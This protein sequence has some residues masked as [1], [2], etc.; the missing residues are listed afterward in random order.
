[1]D[2]TLAQMRAALARRGNPIEMQNI[3]V[4]EAPDISPKAYMPPDNSRSFQPAPGGVAT[5]SGMPVGG[6]DQ[7][8]M[9][10]GQQLMPFSAVQQQQNL[11]G[12][13]P[14][15]MPTGLPGAQG[16]AAPQPPSNILSMTPQGRALSAM[17]PPAVPQ[18]AKGGQPPSDDVKNTRMV[19]NAEG[20]GGVKGI[21]VPRHM[22]EGSKTM[23]GM[24]EVNAARAQ[25]YGEEQRPPLTIGQIGKM[26]RNTLQQHFA[27]PLEQ[28]IEDERAA[29]N[30][31]REAKHI[32]K[33]ADTL[34]ESEK[35][36]T[37]RHERD[38]Q[39][40]TYVGYAS[41][42]VAGH[43]LYTSGHGED[44]KHHVLNTCPGQTEGCGGGKDEKGIVDTTKGTCFAPVA[45][46]Q[47]P[48]AAIRRASHAQA[49]HDPAMTND[50]ILAHTGSIRNAANRAD[51]NNQVL[52]FRPN[53]VD[54][55]DTSSRYVIKHLNN[56]RK[57][58]GKP[59]I[60]ANSYGKT[61]ELHD[62]ENG[63][64]VTHSNVGPK[65][66]HG[67]SIA[68]NI[69]RDNQ[70]VRSTIT[71]TT[72]GGKD[73]EN[74]D[75]NKTPPKGSYMVTNV[76]RGSQRSQEMEKHIKYAKYWSTGR[77]VDQLSKDE[78]DEG[79]EG[80]YGPK[81]K[82][83]TPDKAH[84]GHVTVN[85]KRYDYQK[86]HILHPRLVQVGHNDDGSPHMIPTDSR[87]KDEEFLPKN[88]FMTKNGKMAGHILMTTPTTS[89][90]GVQHHSSFTHD[91]SQEDIEH[92]KKNNGEY[93]IDDPKKQ[94]A[95]AGKEYVPPQQI[96][97]IKKAAGGSIHHPHHEMFDDYMAY[98]ERS[99]MAQMHL[100]RRHDPEEKDEW[101]YPDRKARRPVIVHKNT[102]T[103]KY[104]MAM[105]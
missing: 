93:V 6:I 74:D 90:S 31:L 86:Q 64:Y 34:D 67:K 11:P 63:Y 13:T 28:Q 56:Q 57:A 5:P 51:K 77:P 15:P 22:W 94:E 41:K 95:S 105:K 52:L 58:D 59:G 21:N 87:F 39:G 12:A 79:P 62:P 49:K 2:M 35:L 40:R 18:M 96:S 75:G 32:G 46:A 97:V 44:Q 29:L 27:K 65:T 100:S 72:A 36:D 78:V 83:T 7:S 101:K 26:H 19:F 20:P 68:E 60:V 3:G 92:A 91:V 71:A 30:R 1:M 53:V 85:G 55:T 10:P 73:L 9:V 61:N 103:M 69:A 102:N 45:E 50:W 54:E 47:Y 24:K 33:T 4:N 17:S 84:Y 42:G 25:V 37:V 99:F 76:K 80:H 82:E 16:L 98:P 23:G 38:S 66:K 14:N 104:E 43:A 88:R 70:R 48:G 81:G 8:R 89:T